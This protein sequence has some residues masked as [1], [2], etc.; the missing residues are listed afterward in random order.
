MPHDRN[1][2]RS[3]VSQALIAGAAMTEPG[4]IDQLDFTF[5]D[6]DWKADPLS[7]SRKRQ[8]AGQTRTR[9]GDSRTGRSAQ[10]VFQDEADA[11]AAEGI[12]WDEQCL[13]C[14]GLQP[15]D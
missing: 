1:G 14:I 9:G 3:I 13:V 8:S 7:W 4:T 11:A 15:P 6:D 12:S 10:P 5:V 2:Q